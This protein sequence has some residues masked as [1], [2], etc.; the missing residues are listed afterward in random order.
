MNWIKK[1]VL[2]L[3]EEEIEKMNEEIEAEQEA[4]AAMAA[5]EAAKQQ[6]IAG[7]NPQAGSPS[8]LNTGTPFGA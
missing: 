3:S 7:S 4:Y 8:N 2:H 6:V 5:A 1:N